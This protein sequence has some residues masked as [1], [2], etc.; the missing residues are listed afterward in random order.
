M[1]RSRAPTG[2]WPALG[3]PTEFRAVIRARSALAV[4]HTYICLKKAITLQKRRVES[5]LERSKIPKR[6]AIRLFRHNEIEPP[7]NPPNL[8]QPRPAP[9]P[10]CTRDGHAQA[11]AK[12][13]TTNFVQV[14][15][16]KESEP[17]AR[18][19]RAR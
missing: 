18:Q 16:S 10:A 17:L 5:A 14:P 1:A 9:R 3:I 12:R 2:R 7:G 15:N 19:W 8:H 4:P 13:A 11:R 6:P